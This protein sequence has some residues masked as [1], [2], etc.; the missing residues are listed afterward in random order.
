MQNL[1]PCSREAISD[2]LGARLISRFPGKKQSSF[3]AKLISR[4]PG[5]RSDLV[6]IPHSTL[7]K[8]GGGRRLLVNPKLVLWGSVVRGRPGAD[9]LLGR[10]CVVHCLAKGV[11]PRINSKLVKTSQKPQTANLWKTSQKPASSL[12]GAP[13]ENL[14]KTSLKPVRNFL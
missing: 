1:S 5:K 14:F 6:T 3:G 12:S 11:V 9:R 7:L 13:H 8:G 4:F 2:L 10:S